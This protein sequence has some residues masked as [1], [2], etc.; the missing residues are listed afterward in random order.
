MNQ[1]LCLKENYRWKYGVSKITA[2]IIDSH[3]ATKPKKATL[4]QLINKGTPLCIDEAYR[5]RLLTLG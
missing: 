2:T 5:V 3:E 4:E 1:K